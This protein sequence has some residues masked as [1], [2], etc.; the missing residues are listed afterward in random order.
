MNKKATNNIKFESAALVFVRVHSV[1]SFIRN[2]IRMHI[3]RVK[4]R[5]FGKKCKNRRKCKQLKYVMCC[6]M[7][8]RCNHWTRW[9]G[10]QQ[11]STNRN[12]WSLY[13]DP[14]AIYI[15][16]SICAHARPIR[17]DNKQTNEMVGRSC[18]HSLAGWYWIY[19]HCLYCSLRDTC[20]YWL[21]LVCNRTLFLF[22]GKMKIKSARS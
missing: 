18:T 15:F 21:D 4:C 20:Q 14:F 19:L 17:K 11:C 2:C 9:N 1:F 10:K 3:L 6:V 13:S 22:L 16:F 5:P 8:S 12:L 7:F